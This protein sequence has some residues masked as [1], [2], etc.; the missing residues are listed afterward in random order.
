MNTCYALAVLVRIHLCWYAVP[1]TWAESCEP[2]HNAVQ[3]RLHESQLQ[4]VLD[5]VQDSALLLHR[6][7]ADPRVVIFAISLLKVHDLF[8][9]TCH[10]HHWFE[11]LTD[12]LCD[13]FVQEA[14]QL[15]RRCT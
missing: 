1:S 4:S 12:K 3:R 11:A 14:E 13:V 10:D 5:P 15:S 6:E 7:T 2:D 9:R 8:K